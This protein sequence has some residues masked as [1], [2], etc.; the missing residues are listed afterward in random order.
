MPKYKNRKER[1]TE[2]I[3]AQFTYIN[4]NLDEIINSWWMTRKGEG[5]RLT[6]EG[7]KKFQ[8]AQIEFFNMPLN[9]KHL[10]W[11]KFISDCG[12]KLDCPYFI[13]VNSSTELGKKEPF[14]RLYDS[15]IA[16]LVHL[17]GGIIDYLESVKNDRRKEK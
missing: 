17:Y 3:M 11:N 1:I 15:K 5:L 9:V 6:V 14:I 7:D 8:E 2:A 16:M 12:K 10:S 4:H 13:G